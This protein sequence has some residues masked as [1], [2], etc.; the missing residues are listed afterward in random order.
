MPSS[1]W[2]RPPGTLMFK[3]NGY[4][5]DGRAEPPAEPVQL[6]R[7]GHDRRGWRGMS[8]TSDPEV[9]RRFAAG[10]RHPH[11][12]FPHR[13]VGQVHSATFASEH[14]LAS[15][16]GRGESE[17]VV[18]GHALH[19]DV[20]EALGLTDGGGPGSFELTLIQSDSAPSCFTVT[21]PA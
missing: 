10:L 3:L 8:W 13:S 16:S 2:T 6:Y 5:N 9:A 11:P 7:G 21:R 15:L 14:L 12:D 18:D 20:G 1:S 4:C 19:S 17:F